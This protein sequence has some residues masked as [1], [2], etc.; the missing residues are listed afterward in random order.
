MSDSRIS[1]SWLTCVEFWLYLFGTIFSGVLYTF[2]DGKTKSSPIGSSHISSERTTAP[3]LTFSVLIAVIA[4]TAGTGLVVANILRK[5]DNLVK[6]V[7]TSASIVTIIAAQCV[8]FSDLRR[9]TLTVETVIGAGI[10]AISTWTYHYYKTQRTQR[11]ESVAIRKADLEDADPDH[12]NITMKSEVGLQQ[13]QI[14]NDGEEFRPTMNRII[15]SITTVLFLSAITGFYR[16]GISKSGKIHGDPTLAGDAIQLV[17]DDM[18][19]Y[20]TPHHVKPAIWG[21]TDT[22]YK[23]ISDWVSREKALPYSTKFTDWEVSFL[24]SGCPVYPIPDG[25]LL[26]HQYWPGKWRP[27]NEVAIEAWLATQRLGD[28][29]RL[30]YWYDGE[31]PPAKTR[32]KFQAYQQ[33]MEF[34]ELD[35]RVESKAT[36]VAHMP[37]WTSEEYRKSNSMSVEA[38]SDITRNLLLAKYG[39]VWMNADTVPFRDLTPMIR[40]GPSAGGVR[41]ASISRCGITAK[42][43]LVVRG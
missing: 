36:C 31:G 43:F 9:T 40:S 20:F 34:R 15:L 24:N 19:R 4:A 35:R 13:M 41:Y 37:E 16:S 27:F 33:Y 18:Q 28:G 26:F 32:S 42:L 23:C 17:V 30:I 14:G 25:G 8:L 22:P 1:S 11:H 29:H 2:W 10:I 21:Q 5:K 12:S 38:L 39:G 6:L 3:F 7:G